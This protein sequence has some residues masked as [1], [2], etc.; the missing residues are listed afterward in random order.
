MYEI[1]EAA[2]IT[3]DKKP[4]ITATIIPK[5]ILIISKNL[6]NKQFFSMNTIYPFYA[7]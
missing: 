1:F 3:I 5:I 7:V 6:L 4:I 2:Y